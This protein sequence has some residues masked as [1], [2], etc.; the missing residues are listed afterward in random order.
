MQ[1]EEIWAVEIKNGWN[2]QTTRKEGRSIN[3]D[4]QNAST[5]HQLRGV[6]DS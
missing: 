6:T 4:W 5:H 1:L 3:A 2:L